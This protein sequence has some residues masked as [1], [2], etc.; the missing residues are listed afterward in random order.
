MNPS[1]LEAEESALPYPAPEVSGMNQD[2]EEVDL[3]KV[4][5]AG[6]TVV[7]F[8][9]KADTPGCTKQAC[10]LRDAYEELSERGI[11]VVGVSADGVEAQKAFAEKFELP[12][13][14]I[15]DPDGV[16]IEAFGVERMNN[17]FA[18][19]QAFL[20]HEGKVVWRDA[21]ASTDQQAADVL[22]ALAELGIEKDS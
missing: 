21:K 2:N 16:V 15:A 19:R 17:G 22:K 5:E 10:S 4:Y 20:V 14:L 9:P 13:T 3:A 12:Y 8:Y 18:T 6:P 1:A 11:Q 7:F